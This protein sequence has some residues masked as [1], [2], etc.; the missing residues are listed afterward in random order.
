MTDLQERGFRQ[1]SIP[2]SRVRD[3]ATAEDAPAPESPGTL[4]MPGKVADFL[5]TAELEPA[6][7]AAIVHTDNRCTDV[8]R[9]RT[10]RGPR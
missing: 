8:P 1:A 5:R 2:R 7:R 6:E 9:G 4:D 10:R 3:P